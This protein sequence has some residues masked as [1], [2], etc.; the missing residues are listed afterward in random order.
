MALADADQGVSY[1]RAFL[2][3]CAAYPERSIVPTMKVDEVW[4]AHIGDTAKYREDCQHVF[5][6]PLDH[7]PYAGM[8]G[9]E[10]EKSWR[11]HF[12]ETC[13]LFENHFAIELKSEGGNPCKSHSGGGMCGSGSCE[14]TLTSGERPRPVRDLV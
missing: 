13:R 6:K 14:H 8:R 1:Y 11:A 5:S 9:V 7:F 4:H 12:A 3:L 10:D 2:K